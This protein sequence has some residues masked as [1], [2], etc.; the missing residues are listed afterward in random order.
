LINNNYVIGSVVGIGVLLSG[1]QSV[2]WMS[3]A[4]VA[5]SWVL[6]PVIGGIF[7]C[8]CWFLLQKFVIH[9]KTNQR[10]KIFIVMPILF[11]LTIFILSLFL[12]YQV[13]KAILNNVPIYIVLPA[14]LVVSIVSGILV[15]FI[16]VRRLQARVDAD[17]EAMKKKLEE[18]AAATNNASDTNNITMNVVTESDAFSQDIFEVELPPT[19]AHV[20]ASSAPFNDV[21]GASSVD[22]EDTTEQQVPIISADAQKQ[23][24]VNEELVVID[25]NSGPISTE[26]TQ[27]SEQPPQEEKGTMAAVPPRKSVALTDEEKKKALVAAEA[28]A[29][30]AQFHEPKTEAEIAEQYAFN[31]LVILTSCCIAMAYVYNCVLCLV[32]T[33]I[34]YIII[35]FL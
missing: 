29:A 11:A 12:V 25:I 33:N 8:I 14:A 5:A 9:A 18:Q 26:V 23:Q 31:F 16:V 13:L 17:W 6:S 2:N 24:L 22:A 30:N 15:H 7:S 32:V 27:T 19:P 21:T 28:A 35:P 4:T 10:K 3:M 34:N 1:W 20:I